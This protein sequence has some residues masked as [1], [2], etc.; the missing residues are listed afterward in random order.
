MPKTIQEL[1]A[2]TSIDPDFFSEL[3]E[4]LSTTEISDYNV[5]KYLE[6]NGV[7]CTIRFD[8]QKNAHLSNVNC[9]DCDIRVDY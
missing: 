9:V 5:N 1:Q 2:E 8:K 3:T 6:V 4:Y 7:T